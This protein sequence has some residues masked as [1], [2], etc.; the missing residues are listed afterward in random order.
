VEDEI[1][2]RPK[3]HRTHEY[4]EQVR[5]LLRLGRH[6]SIRAT[7]MQLNLYEETDKF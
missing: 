2:G 4:V 1:A 7:A 5:N 6:L 3:F